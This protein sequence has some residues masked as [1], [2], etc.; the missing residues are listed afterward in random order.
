[1]PTALREP[2]SG[3]ISSVMAMMRLEKWVVAALLAAAGPALA[4]S[5][6]PIQ[7]LDLPAIQGQYNSAI[8]Q[9]NL[10]TQLNTLRV[11]QG[12][13]QDRIRELDLFRPQTPYGAG[14]IFQPQPSGL[15]PL[16]QPP[17]PPPPPPPP[18]PPAPPAE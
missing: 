6:P 5:P 18:K 10:G 4:Q 16:P 11:E 15:A 3:S 7:P 9:Q 2:G 1:M 14:A 17:A 8:Q 13:T 12:I